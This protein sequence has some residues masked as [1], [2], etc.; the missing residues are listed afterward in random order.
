MRWSLRALFFGVALKSATLAASA[1]PQMSIRGVDGGLYEVQGTF[2][3]KASVEQAWSLL[4]DYGHLKGTV[5][6]LV[7][8]DVMEKEGDHVV[9]E[10]QAKGAFL[11]FTHVV[12]VRLKI[13]EKKLRRID[14]ED[15]LK[16]DF[17]VYKGSWE[18]EP[19]ATGVHV[20]YKLTADRGRFA[21]EAIEQYVFKGQAATMLGQ[22][23]AKLEAKAP[24][25]APIAAGIDHSHT[26]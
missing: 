5:E 18:I 9:V 15:V 17:G 10:Q 13:F 21:P 1:L 11:F 24:T 3:A 6:S 26:N 14:F 25:E 12:K 16:K 7:Q 4:S 23:K 2:D 19:S 22:I 8:S 20:T